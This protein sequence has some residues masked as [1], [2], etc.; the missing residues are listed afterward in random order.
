MNKRTMIVMAAVLG[1][2][3]GG[4]AVSRLHIHHG[5]ESPATAVAPS[6]PI[7][8]LARTR[9]WQLPTSTFVPGAIGAAPWMYP[10]KP[11]LIGVSAAPPK[12]AA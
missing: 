3:A 7:V 6:P 2:G 11:P 1:L 4:I 9:P 5:E 8:M 10:R 12:P